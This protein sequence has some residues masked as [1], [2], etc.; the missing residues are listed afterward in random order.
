MWTLPI[1]L[2]ASHQQGCAPPPAIFQL[3]S[4]MTP[5]HRTC[6]HMSFSNTPTCQPA[7]LYGRSVYCAI[8]GLHL[9]HFIVAGCRGN[10]RIG[11]HL[12]RWALDGGSHAPLVSGTSCSCCRTLGTGESVFSSGRPIH[13]G[14][15]DSVLGTSRCVRYGRTC[16][17]CGGL[18][19]ELLC[20][21]MNS[22]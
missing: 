15:L 9:T 13:S 18:Q 16:L 11:G 17:T 19:H 5:I 10:L 8:V 22:V 3:Y 7:S 20:E 12:V 1:P 21:S 2:C 6:C 4:H 14:G